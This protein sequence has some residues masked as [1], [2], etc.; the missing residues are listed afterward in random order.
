M[1]QDE[2]IIRFIDKLDKMYADKIYAKTSNTDIE[3]E[4]K[5]YMNG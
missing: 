2:L 4:Y 5:K 1:R 3:Y